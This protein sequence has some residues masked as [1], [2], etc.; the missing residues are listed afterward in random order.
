MVF[1]PPGM[2]FCL[3]R[4]GSQMCGNLKW[5]IKWHLSTHLFPSWKMEKYVTCQH[6]NR[7]NRQPNLPHSLTIHSQR[8]LLNIT[9]YECEHHLPVCDQ[10]NKWRG[11]RRAAG[12]PFRTKLQERWFCE[13]QNHQR[14]SKAYVFI[15]SFLFI[16]I[17][18]IYPNITS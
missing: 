11:S 15:I 2:A 17:F 9:V 16:V 6:L 14:Y 5:F 18:V 7:L 3:I 1:F 10:Q 8:K 4:R 12:R 13:R